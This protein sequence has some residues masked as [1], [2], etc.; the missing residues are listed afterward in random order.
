MKKACSYYKIVYI[1]ILSFIFNYINLQFSYAEAATDM[2][3]KPISKYYHTTLEITDDYIIQEGKHNPAKDGTIRYRTIGYY[4]TKEPFD[5]TTKLNSGKNVSIQDEYLPGKVGASYIDGDGM[6]V[7]PYTIRMSDFTSTVAKLQIDGDYIVQ[8]NGVS[9]YMHNVFESYLNNSTL[10]S[11]LYGKQEFLA[12]HDWSDTT[13][14]VIDSYYNYEFK[15]T[16]EAVYQV[17]F[18]AVDKDYNILKNPSNKNNVKISNPLHTMYAICGQKI[19]YALEGSNSEL[20]SNHNK[21]TYTNTWKYEYTQKNGTKVSSSP[22]PGKDVLIKDAP[23]ALPGSVMTV[24]LVY[25]TKTEPYYYKV[26]AIDD[27]GNLLRYNIEDKVETYYGDIVTYRPISTITVNG[28]EYHFQRK[29][30]LTYEN[31]AD[32]KQKT[33]SRDQEE[34]VNKYSMPDAKYNSVAEFSMVYS[35]GPVPSLI[36]TPTPKPGTPSPTPKPGPTPTP[37]LPPVVVPTPD[38]TSMEFTAVINTG[39]LRAD[40]RG[41]ERFIAPLAVPTTESLYGEVTAKEYLL[42]YS[43]VKKVGIKYYTIEVKKDYILNY[44]TATP[45]SAGGGT[46]VTETITVAQRISVP[47]AYGYWQIENLEYYQI[48]HAVLNN[49]ALPNGSITI[50]PNKSYYHPPSI[51]LSH[52]S[53]ES[54]HII[55]PQETVTGITL[56]SEII[57]DPSDPIRKPNIPTEDFSYFAY[58]QTGQIKVRS[59]SLIFQGKTVIDNA[60]TEREAPDIQTFAIPQ[61]FTFIDSNVL[62]QPD[63]VIEASKKNGTYPSNGTI[64]YTSI[65]AVNPTRP[66]KPQYPIDGIND[67][68][69]HTP[70][71]CLPTITA[72]NDRYVQLINPTEGCIP[73]V[74][75]PDPRLSDFTVTISNYGHHSNQLGYYIRDFSR[76]LRDSEVSYIA[77]SNG[78]LR[79][80]VQFPFDVYLDLGKDND[81][82]NDK[83][84]KAG[85]WIVIG[86]SSPRFYLPM[87]TAEDVYTVNFRT[88]AVNGESFLNKTQTYANQDIR[89][90]VATNT[91]DVEVS[92]RIYGLTVYDIS[93]YPLWEETFRV[94][95]SKDLKKDDPNYPDGTKGKVYDKQNS[96]T[97]TIGTHDQYGNDTGRMNKYTFPLVNGSH[98]LYKNIGIL[99]TGYLFRYSLETTG[100]MYSDANMVIIKP[101]FYYVDKNGK[102]RKAVDL[103]YTEEIYQKNRHLVKVGSAL[104]QTNMKS[105]EIGDVYLGIPK[106]ELRQTAEIRNVPYN[107]YKTIREY[108]YHFSEIRLNTAFRTYVNEGYTNNI[109]SY[110]SF[111]AVKSKGVTEH[112]ITS[113][114][115]RW[116]GEYYLPNE[117]HAV[118]KGFDVMDYAD[119]YG[120]DYSEDFWLT[121]GYIIVN[122]NIETLDQDGKRRLS[123]TNAANHVNKD[124]CSMWIMEGPVTEKK[125]YYGTKFKFYAGDVMVYEAGKRMTDDYR[126][127]VVY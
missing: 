58:A 40:V 51:H 123:Y 44:E 62:Y 119:K 39:K 5:T 89:N 81:P 108:L 106:N 53:N 6:K 3:I 98:P 22:Y 46:P 49:Y 124:H 59:D 75:D 113:C 61:C 11:P 67:V 114:K 90:Y 45:G 21:Y 15:L 105:V 107:K 13:R 100:M 125:D 122:F 69:L 8:H 116:Y 66:M 19:P 88:I 56:P 74:L 26:K 115:Q 86:R 57:S 35:A 97:Y 109:K 78:T 2:W 99:K 71:V 27:N 65:A 41:E 94:P 9:V 4:L 25:D 64:I 118:Q 20:T 24:Y 17:E 126:T 36:P 55:P 111:E 117:V 120:V 37:F 87:W 34:M 121:E 14:R 110:S 52:S 93:D 104:D 76:S 92:G 16:K 70:A 23:D 91:L 84:V 38:M 82:S 42:G 28:K 83:Y 50:A 73:L 31:R 29:W 68:V 63:Q 72:D 96:Y 95:K 7:T 10:K 54:D 79:N 112:D 30:Y 1:I 77:T 43:F 48:D 103:Y 127:G 60:I 18:V 12:A 80:E 101:S 102:N 32:G 47:R 33:I 85:T